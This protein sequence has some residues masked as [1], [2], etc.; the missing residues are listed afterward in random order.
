MFDS[1]SRYNGVSLL[2]YD[3]ADGRTV[4]Y[5]ARRF[6]PRPDNYDLL[7]LHTVTEGD[8]LDNIANTYLDDPQQFWRICDANECVSP[9]DLTE[10][11]G[12]RI[13]IT[14]PQGIPG[15]SRA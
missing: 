7:L 13:R 14:L 9:F 11:P 1:A 5:V 2:P 8:R 3:T 6:L 10:Q 4:N 15:P 12:T